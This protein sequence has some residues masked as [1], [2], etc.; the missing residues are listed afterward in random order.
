MESS[1]V[2]PQLFLLDPDP[3][4]RNPEVRVRICVE[5]R[6]RDELSLNELFHNFLTGIIYPLDKASLTDVS[7]P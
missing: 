3:R 4:I 5:T 6:C 1:V 2:N 7:R